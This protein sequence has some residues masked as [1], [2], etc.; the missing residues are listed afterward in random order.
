MI[1]LVGRVTD[2]ASMISRP[3]SGAGNQAIHTTPEH[4]TRFVAEFAVEERFDAVNFVL[5]EET[6]E[7][8]LRFGADVVVPA[9][10]APGR[11]WPWRHAARAIRVGRPSG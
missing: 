4:W 2:T 5:D 10:Q 6:T 7:Q 3:R 8:I 9:R 11:L 1:Q